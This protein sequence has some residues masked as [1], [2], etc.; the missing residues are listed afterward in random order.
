[1]VISIHSQFNGGCF[2]ISSPEILHIWRLV[3]LETI[4]ASRTTNSYCLDCRCYFI[5]GVSFGA[6]ADQKAGETKQQRGLIKVHQDDGKEVIFMLTKHDVLVCANELGISQKR[7]TDDVIELVKR[8]ISL[9]FSNCPEV[10]KSALT[11]AVECPLGLVC[12][13]SCFWW[14][15][16]K[17][18]F[19]GKKEK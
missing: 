10:V 9:S 13:P 5:D 18:T 17:C 12:Y 4:L 11:E 1:M 8:R 2:R 14:K 15:D 3:Q 6:L 7:V 19:P 16:G